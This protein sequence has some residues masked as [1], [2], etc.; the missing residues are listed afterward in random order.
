M[1]LVA[2]L[3]V[4]SAVGLCALA[5]ANAMKTQTR[6]V[7]NRQIFDG[8]IDR[9]L[10]AGNVWTRRDAKRE[11]CRRNS[12]GEKLWRDRQDSV[13]NPTITLLAFGTV[14]LGKFRP[15]KNNGRTG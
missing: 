2:A 10:S 5:Q 3:G 1:P 13:K 11:S 14:V 12:G 7:V 15:G 6:T 9:N 4:G 8:R